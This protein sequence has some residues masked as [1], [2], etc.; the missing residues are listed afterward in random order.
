M[1]KNGVQH[2]AE[3]IP[4]DLSSDGYFDDKENGK[5][6]FIKTEITPAFINDTDGISHISLTNDSII[7]TYSIN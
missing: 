2:G 3:I 4:L 5:I 6:N 7:I 1:V